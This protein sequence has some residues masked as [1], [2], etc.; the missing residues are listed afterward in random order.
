MRQG[1]INQNESLVNINEPSSTP[2]ITSSVCVAAAIVKSISR[3]LKFHFY[4]DQML[5]DPFLSKL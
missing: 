2:S 5:V 4:R 1:D 3:D